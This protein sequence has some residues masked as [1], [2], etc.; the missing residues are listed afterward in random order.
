M[1]NAFLLLLNTIQIW[2]VS[3]HGD[4]CGDV[5]SIDIGSQPKD[6]SI[7]SLSPELALV[8]TDSGVVMLRGTKLVSTIGLGFPVTASAV[9]PNGSEAII[10]RQDGK[11]HV[12]SINGDT[13]TEEKVLEKHRCAISVIRYSPDFSM[14]A[15]SDVNREAIVWDRLSHEV[16]LKNMLHHTARINCLAWSHNSSMVVA[17]SLDTCHHL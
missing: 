14:F 16:K 1:S 15:S 7:A 17:G 12:Y 5:E 3:L 6:L 11:Q 8:T 2:R 9:A 4:Q 10:G 13:L